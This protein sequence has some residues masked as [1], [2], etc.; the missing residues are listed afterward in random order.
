MIPVQQN[1]TGMS[2]TCFSACL[3]SILEVGLTAI[4]E[5]GGDDVWL[6]NVTAFLSDYGLYY[7]QVPPDDPILGI[8][9]RHGLTWHTVEGISNR[10]GPHAVVGCNGDIVHDPHPGGNG[11]KK[12]ECFGLI[13]NRMTSSFPRQNGTGMY[14]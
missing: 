5:F 3:A 9:F 11:L 14:L 10:G 12:V 8:V 13:C 4:P 7:V 1:R 6:Q 2:G